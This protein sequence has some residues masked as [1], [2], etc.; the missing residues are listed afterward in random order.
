[1]D[2]GM[3]GD[4]LAVKARLSHKNPLDKAVQKL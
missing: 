1:M 2:S 3:D 4:G